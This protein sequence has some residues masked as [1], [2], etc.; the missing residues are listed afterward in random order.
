M[1]SAELEVQP[2]HLEPIYSILLCVGLSDVV[3]HIGGRSPMSVRSVSLR[4]LS[5]L[6]L[7]LF[8]STKQ[9]MVEIRKESACFKT[10][11][12]KPY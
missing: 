8:Y 11:E 12:S 4:P 2:S 10:G 3:Q 1:W 5:H 9:T 6:L 7:Y